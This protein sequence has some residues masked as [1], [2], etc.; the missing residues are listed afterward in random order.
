[1]TLVL[2]I[3]ILA[4]LILIFLVFTNPIFATL[5]LIS[6][7]FATLVLAIINFTIINISRP[8]PTTLVSITPTFSIL[9]QPTLFIKMMLVMI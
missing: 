7:I 9:A 2:A 6:S 1:M 8:A 5:I 4:T 3:P